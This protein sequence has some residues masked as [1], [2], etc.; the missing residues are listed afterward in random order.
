[1]LPMS[2]SMK[3]CSRRAKGPP[4]EMESL[5]RSDVGCATVD[6]MGHGAPKNVTSV[7]ILRSFRPPP[8]A[9]PERA[10]P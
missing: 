6:Q 10:R 9:R 1:M 4:G 7:Y 5:S 2:M 3:V 8:Y